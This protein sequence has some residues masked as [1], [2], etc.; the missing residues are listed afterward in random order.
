MID[1]AVRIKRGARYCIAL[2]VLILISTIS[3]P[4]QADAL[5][6]WQAGYDA[7]QAGNPDLAIHHYTSAI[8]SGELNQRSL[9]RVASRSHCYLLPE[10]TRSNSVSKTRAIPG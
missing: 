9:A 8:R 3:P 6:D 10:R 2:L 4:V 1:L 5:E 7:E